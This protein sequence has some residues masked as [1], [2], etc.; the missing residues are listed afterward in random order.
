MTSR[1]NQS[2]QLDSA[3]LALS[4]LCMFHCMAGLWLV[5]SVASVSGV[6]FS[7]VVHELG[8]AIAAFIA[9]LAL[10]HGA[11][12]HGNLVPLAVGSFGIGV[13][14]GAIEL[15]EIGELPFTILG[16]LLL[17]AGHI[18]NFRANAH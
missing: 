9:A 10:G 6:F 2:G 3:A 11:M 5:A 12:R 4:I 17:S 7:P 13:M 15:P 1:F 16:V 18:L 14:A 8:L